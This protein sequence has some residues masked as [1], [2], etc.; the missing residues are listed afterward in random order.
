MTDADDRLRPGMTANID[1]R[2]QRREGVLTVPIEA[3]FRKEGRDVVYLMV[4]GEPVE[5][6][7]EIGLVDIASAEI[8]EGVSEGDLVALEEPP[9]PTE[10][11]E[12]E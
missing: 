5:T 12:E 3:V 4:D 2:G 9:E 11:E 6:P 1:I 7:V 8:V 10:E